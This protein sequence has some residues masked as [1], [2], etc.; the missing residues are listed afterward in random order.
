MTRLVQISG[1]IMDHVYRIR[2]IPAPGTEAEVR[3]AFL[4]PGGGFNA[5]VAA[6]R[7]G[8]EVV[9]G[10]TLGSG[11]FADRIAQALADSGIE[12]LRPRLRGLDQGVCTVL[13][14]YTGE[15]SFIASEGADGLVTDADLAGL[16]LRTDDWLLLSGYALLYKGSRDA[17]TRWLTKRPGRLVFDPCPQI[18]AIPAESRAAA[19]QAAH[20]ISANRAEAATLTGQSDPARA[21]RQLADRPG[22]AV[23]R[24]GAQ[25]AWLAT[26]GAQ[27]VHLPAFPVRVVDTNGAG[28]THVGAFIAALAAGH[29]PVESCR[30]ANIAAALSITRAGP[31]TAP[32]LS[33][34]LAHAAPSLKES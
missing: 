12:A 22:G 17:L 25:G 30:L 11:P 24:D 1:V 2:A 8:L 21:A 10:G 7:M 3:S 31:A 6:Q 34:V 9:Y 18:G 19:L 4:T 14:D 5:M 28:D 23:V 20:W 27:A 33:D 15:R 13:I 16:P 32:N 26:P 29:P